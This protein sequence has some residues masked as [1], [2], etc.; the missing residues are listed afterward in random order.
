MALHSALPFEMYNQFADQSSMS[1]KG[2]KR[3]F[4]IVQDSED[5]EETLVS[6]MK[7]IKISSDNVDSS[8]ELKIMETKKKDVGYEDVGGMRKQMAQIRELVELPLKQPKLFKT[9]GVKPP[10]GILLYGPPGSGK[11]LIA[12]AIAS[13]TGGLVFVRQWTGDHVENGWGE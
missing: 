11:T 1:N 2:T 4:S 5:G 13:E 6:A 3:E 7:R 10:K 12:R 8:Q 9:I